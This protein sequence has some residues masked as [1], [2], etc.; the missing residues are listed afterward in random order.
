MRRQF[1]K[2]MT[3]RTSEAAAR[4]LRTFICLAPPSAPV[5]RRLARRPRRAFADRFYYLGDPEVVPVPMQGLLSE[6]HAAALAAG[7]D[8]AH[9]SWSAAGAAPGAP[10]PWV[11]FA[12]T[13]PPGDPWQFDPG[14]R[15]SG[16]IAGVAAS[17]DSD[18]CTTHFAVMDADHNAV[19]CTIT[20]AGIFGGG[21]V[22]PGTGVL[23]NNGMTWFNPL[24]GAANSIAPGKRAL[25]NMTPVMML[26]DSRPYLLIGAPGGRKIVSAIAQ[27]ISNVVDHGLSMQA[28]ITAPR[29]DASANETIADVRL[30]PAVVEGLRARG[31]AVR[32]VEDLPGSANFSRPLSILVD[33]DGGLHSG[34][35]PF[36]TAEALGLE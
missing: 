24:P 30:V 16:A 12:A 31:H 11:R 17:G 22:T 7:I 34:L 26:R 23:W 18:T 10:E 6:R 19:C 33:R 21:V 4:L 28:A 13:P 35:T 3:A 2:M 36:H 29:I 15:P 32:E 1:R 25:T 8:R 5:A 9:A 20:F 14:V 27:I